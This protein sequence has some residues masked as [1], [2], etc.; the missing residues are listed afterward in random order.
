MKQECGIVSKILNI[1]HILKYC[2]S[3][4]MDLNFQYRPSLD[5]YKSN[6]S[7]KRGIQIPINCILGKFNQ[8]KSVTDATLYIDTTKQL[9]IVG[10]NLLVF[11]R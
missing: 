2:I 5:T 6:V 9:L 3:I 8:S 10:L 11:A 4:V 7:L 1:G